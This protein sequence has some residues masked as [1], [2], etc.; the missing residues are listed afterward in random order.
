MFIETGYFDSCL[1]PP[2]APLWFSG[3]MTLKYGKSLL[4]LGKVFVIRIFNTIGGDGKCFQ[5]HVQSNRHPGR[6]QRFHLNI[7]TTQ[8]DKVFPARILADGCGQN[9]AFHFLRNT[10]FYK[11][12]FRQPDGFFQNS[13]GMT[14]IPASIASPVIS[15]A[16]EFWI[17]RLLALLQ[18]LE[19]VLV[20]SIQCLQ[21][22]FE[23]SCVHFL[24][25]SQLLFQYS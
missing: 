9:T 18:P 24:K 23:R 13:D 16:F 3:E 12:K 14:R 2:F 19:E 17:A 6:R 15:F 11:T 21:R 1:F 22:R 7:G 4:T 20:G 25:P 5:A 8:S 10:A